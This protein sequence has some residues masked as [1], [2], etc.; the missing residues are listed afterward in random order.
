MLYFNIL[1][2]M[3][4]M[5]KCNKCGKEIYKPIRI[6]KNHIFNIEAYYCDEC[7][8]NFKVIS[9]NLDFA[10]FSDSIIQIEITT[11]KNS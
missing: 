7:N 2:R 3:A 6:L 4:L 8:L 1:L 10:D 11:K 9:N 5:A